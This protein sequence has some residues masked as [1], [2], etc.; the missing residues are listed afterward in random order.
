MPA[1]DEEFVEAIYRDKQ[2]TL[3]RLLPQIVNVD[4]ATDA[5]ITAL[6]CAARENNLNLLSQLLARH[7]NVSLTDPD[8]RQALHLACILNDST[9]R[10]GIDLLI[11]AGADLEHTDNKGDTPL[12]TAVRCARGGSTGG[13]NLDRVSALLEA[14]ANINHSNAKGETSLMVAARRGDVELI[15]LLLAQGAEVNYVAESSRIQHQHHTVRPGA[16]ALMLATESGNLMAVQSLLKAGA[17]ITALDDENHSLLYYALK[18]G[19]PEVVS[20]LVEHGLDVDHRDLDGLTTLEW[21]S[22]QNHKDHNIADCL[23][24][25]GANPNCINPKPPFSG[26]SLLMVAAKGNDVKMV[27]LLLRHGADIDY[28]SPKGESVF[29]VTKH[30][31]IQNILKSHAAKERKEAVSASIALSRLEKGVPNEE[32][33]ATKK[34]YPE[35]IVTHVSTF[36]SKNEAIRK[37]VR[38]L[39]KH[40]N[41]DQNTA[42]DVHSVR[43]PGSS[44]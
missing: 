40:E 16:T 37:G 26:R 32:G 13:D 31:D 19:R 38:A 25:H 33:K 28:K 4:L 17:N 3:E 2:T 34:P 22:L 41:K 10:K 5:G 9:D 1:I 20:F 44:K 39:R 36:L 15:N 24:Q 12:L 18:S 14:G 29:S 21:A 7:A 23:L 11:K 43:G 6:M 27:E 42:D 8:G 35:D 30:P